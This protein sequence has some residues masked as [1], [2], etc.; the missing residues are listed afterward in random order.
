[1]TRLPL[2]ALPGLLGANAAF[3]APGVAMADLSAVIMSL[4]LVI[5]F[6]FAA[7]WAVRR[8]PFGVGRGNGPLKVMAALS[9]GPKERLLLV[10]ARGEEILLAVSPAG[11]FNVGATQSA[12]AS[13]SVRLPSTEPKFVLPD[14]T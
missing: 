7:A 2:I 10:E 12:D 6:I 14:P 11:V 9:L 5:A 3:A 4:A 1:M 8:M 13:G